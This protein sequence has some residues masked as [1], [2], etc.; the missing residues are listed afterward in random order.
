MEINKLTGRVIGIAMDVH[1]KLGLGLLESAYKECLFYKLKQNNL[2]VE[3]EKP[4]P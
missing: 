2:W 1:Y 4:I 3:K